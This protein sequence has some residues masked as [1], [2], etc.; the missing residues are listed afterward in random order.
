MRRI[1][2]LAPAG[3]KEIFKAAVDSGADAVY[4]GTDIFNARMNAGNLTLDDLAECIYYAHERSASVHLTLNTLVNDMELPEAAELSREVYNLGADAV[5]VQD[6]GL[7]RM[8]NERFPDIPLHASTQMNIFEE[9]GLR[10][11]AGNGFTRV[12]LPRELSLREIRSVSSLAH[13]YGIETEAFIHGAVC[14]CTSGL[15]L[16]SAMNRSGTRS[17]NRGMCAQPCRQAYDLESEGKTLYSGHILSPK[18]RC[19]VRFIP[20]LIEAGVSSLKI[21]G[22]MRD[23]DYVTTAVRTYREIIDAYY[24]GSPVEDIIEKSEKR[25]LVNFNR[26]GSFTSQNLSGRKDPSIL[27]GEYVGKYGVKIGRVTLRD[28]REGTITIRPVKDAVL[29]SSGDYISLRENNGEIRSF[30]AGK[31]STYKGS[32]VIKGLHPDAIR[33][34]PDRTD[35]YTYRVRR[36]EFDRRVDYFFVPENITFDGSAPGVLKATAVVNAGPYEGIYAESDIDYEIS[37]RLI[38]DDRIREQLKKTGSSPFSVEQIYVSEGDV[39]CRIRDLNE[40]RRD[41]LEQL[42]SRIAI[43]SSHF[44]KENFSISIEKERTNQNFKPS[45]VKKLIYY[46]S[47]RLHKSDFKDCDIYAFSVYDYLNPEYKEEIERLIRMTDKKLMLVKP[48]FYHENLGRMIRKLKDFD[49]MPTAGSN[50]Y[51]SASLSYRLVKTGSAFLS[52]ELS[53]DEAISLLKKTDVK[54]DIFLHFGGPVPWMQSDFCPV[55]RNADGCSACRRRG[56]YSIRQENG[57]DLTVITHPEDCSS[58]I[59]GPAKNIFDD[60]DAREISSLGFNVIKCYT[61]VF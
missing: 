33:K 15:C 6:I 19:A 60:D 23:K 59:Y 21:E 48:D 44:A 11:L 52:Y 32:Y 36:N 22:R 43:E 27:S 50:I 57:E 12:V 31:V 42:S 26:G 4:C 3:N 54:G 18:D 16:F 17:G 51:N 46:P 10:G 58:V 56:P 53:R 25:L 40:L 2:L 45:P 35:A 14:I 13:K 38:S 24:S 61:E 8:I 29:P 5:L 30:P 28:C 37:D 41:M 49:Y 39:S 7:A 34:L 9:E 20:E 55:G 1:E 47:L